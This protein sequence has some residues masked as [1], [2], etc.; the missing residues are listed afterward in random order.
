MDFKIL[1]IST[2]VGVISSI[3]TAYVT[4]KL[5][6]N[7]ELKKWN[8]DFGIKYAEVKAENLEHAEFLS[9]QYALGYLKIFRKDEAETE[10]IFIPAN[11]NLV[12]GRGRGDD[13]FL[14]NVPY[15]SRKHLLFRADS[16]KVVVSTL[17]THGAIL[18]RNNEETQ[19]FHG[20]SVLQD[21]DKLIV[22]SLSIVFRYLRS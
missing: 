7:Q 16:T 9:A 18:V 12:A 22:G 15:I 1:I 3:I 13:I 17:G 11:C 19:L 8:R 10:K 2:V 4:A 5:K 6:F 14:G 21:E 20:E